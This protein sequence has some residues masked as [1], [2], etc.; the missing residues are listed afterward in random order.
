MSRI[1][2]LRLL[3][4]AGGL[5][6]V[7]GALRIAR[8]EEELADVRCRLQALL[9]QADDALQLQVARDHAAHLGG[10]VLQLLEAAAGKQRLELGANLDRRRRARGRRPAAVQLGQL[11]QLARQTIEV[12][13]QGMVAGRPRRLRRG[14]VAPPQVVD[15]HRPG[16]AFQP[17]L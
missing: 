14:R 3:H 1:E 15:R 5:G 11:G 17:L 13:P 6:G 9:G 10:A 4:Q 2:R 8:R 7:A 12:G 16:S